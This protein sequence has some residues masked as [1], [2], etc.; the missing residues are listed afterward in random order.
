MADFLV[1]IWHRRILNPCPS[2][3]CVVARGVEGM[4]LGLECWVGLGVCVGLGAGPSC[5]NRLKNEMKWNFDFKFETKTEVN[6]KKIGHWNEL[7]W[8]EMKSF[9]IASVGP[10]WERGVSETR[11]PYYICHKTQQTNWDHPKY[12]DFMMDLCNF[13]SIKFSAYRTSVKLR[14]LQKR[15]CRKEKKN[16]EKFS[17]FFFQKKF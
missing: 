17:I 13:N 8:I 1:W 7:K 15:L 14:A 10:P 2:R 11:V 16:E 12:N 6:Q 3:T 5:S 9:F 4:G